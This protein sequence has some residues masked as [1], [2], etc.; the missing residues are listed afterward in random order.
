MRLPPCWGLSLHLL[1]H[2]SQ[3]PASFCYILISRST[4]LPLC[5]EMCLALGSFITHLE[6]R[7]L[8]ITPGAHL[9]SFRLAEDKCLVQSFL[10]CIKICR[11]EEKGIFLW[12]NTWKVD[13]FRAS[14]IPAGSGNISSH[15]SAVMDWTARWG[16]QCWSSPQLVRHRPAGA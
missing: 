2:I 7:E 14:V 4:V 8:L 5:T 6:T 15:V 13:V 11:V 1:K 10:S 12:F 16:C 3:R 9:K